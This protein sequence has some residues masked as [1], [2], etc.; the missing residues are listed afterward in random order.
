MYKAVYNFLYDHYDI[1]EYA[2]IPKVK[3]NEAL[4][5]IENWYQA[6]DLQLSIDISNNC[7][8]QKMDLDRRL[9]FG[10][11]QENSF[12]SNKD[13]RELYEIS[14]AQA[15]RHMRRMK[16]IYEIDE[17][18]L[19]RR[20]VLPV[21]IADISIKAKRKRMLIYHFLLNIRRR[22]LLL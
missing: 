14:E 4:S 6:Y 22:N 15:Y 5:L 8:Q 7:K 1:S 11:T 13:I 17:N 9:V 16:E 3:Y 21:A 19:P 12:Y 10:V 18:R 2:D 20:G